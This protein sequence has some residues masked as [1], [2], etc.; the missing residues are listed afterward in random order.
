MVTGRE[1]GSQRETLPTLQFCLKQDLL[2]GLHRKEKQNH[3]KESLL[4]GKICPNKGK[5]KGQEDMETRVWTHPLLGKADSCKGQD[6]MS[7]Q[8]TLLPCQFLIITARIYLLSQSTTQRNQEGCSGP[9][10]GTDVYSSAQSALP[11]C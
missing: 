1:G 6:L 8:E 7:V 9:G 11:F 5:G 4:P 3:K 10:E 2:T